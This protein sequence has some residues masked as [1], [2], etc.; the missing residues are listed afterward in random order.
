M[1]EETAVKIYVERIIVEEKYS[2]SL[3]SIKVYKGKIFSK[4]NVTSHE[5]ENFLKN[6]S[7][8]S[9][10]WTHFFKRAD[11]YLSELKESEAIQ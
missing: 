10:R 11:T 1:D 4:Y 3:D 9:E 5:Y 8:D 7:D 2:F 6:L